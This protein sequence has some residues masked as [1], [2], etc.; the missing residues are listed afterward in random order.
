M[1][2]HRSPL[3]P[4]AVAAA[5]AL[6][7]GTALAAHAQT[8]PAPVAASGTLLSISAEG[9]VQRAPD[10][11]HLSTGVVTRAADAQA[12]MNAN[13]EQM[14]KV[15]AAIRQAGIAEDDIRTSGVNLFPQYRHAPDQAPE[16]TGYEAHNTVEITVREIGRLGDVIDALVAAGA[17]QINGPRFEVADKQAAF[18]EA[19]R[20]ALENA[21]ERARMYAQTLD[22]QVQ[23]IVSISEGHGYAPPRPVPMMAMARM[24]SAAD[25]P[26]EPGQSTLSVTLDVVFELD[27]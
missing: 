2:D 10:I 13:A 8:V 4:L 21:R 22:M 3:R 23:R 11:A 27:Q 17:N 18:D 19:R 12:A 6:G 7:L 15:I 5:L 25:T 26:I 1:S 20:I 24:E 9:E 14:Q 16:I